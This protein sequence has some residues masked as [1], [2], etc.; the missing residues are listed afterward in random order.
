[1]LCTCK[2]VI[3]PSSRRAD[4]T[5]NVKIRIT[6]DRRSRWLPTPVYVTRD[7]LTRGYKLKDPTALMLAERHAAAVRDALAQM[8]P[9]WL[10]GRTVDDAVAW[11][12]SRLGTRAF[13][14]DLLEFG[15]GFAATKGE[16]T[17][18]AYR[19]ALNAL[20]RYCGREQ[21]DVSEVTAQLLREFADSLTPASAS[22]YLGK[23]HAV[24]QAAQRRYNDPDAGV[25]RI[26]RDPFRGLELE[27]PVRRGQRSLGVEA[28]QRIIDAQTEDPKLRRALDWFVISFALMGMNY[29]DLYGAK[30]PRR[31][32]LEYER[33]K[34]AGRRADGA[35][36]RVRVPA[37]L[38]PFVARQRA[39]NGPWWLKAR[40]DRGEQT[41]AGD[42]ND[43]LRSWAR[44]EGLPEFTFYA[45]RHTFATVARSAA[46]GIP[47]PVIEDCLNH[48]AQGLLDIY[49][50][51][52]W[53]V[54]DGA[55]ARVLA[56]F[57]W[58]ETD[59]K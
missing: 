29:I 26:P 44:A 39:K 11:V 22:S 40:R 15:R 23:L 33:R 7:Q 6:Y 12:R 54:L 17:G 19:V 34:T 36:M 24:W 55:N 49:A 10:D 20:G 9:F 42:I 53:D 58:P 45:A 31:G 2:A 1:M 43:R 27:R 56:L 47:Y 8:P 4:G 37:C 41:L 18:K 51:R 16:A 59:G 3:L 48:K 21:L 14:L 5:W 32:V 30:P 38:E 46:A 35:L 28:M 52:D 13:R 25:E 50:E 57:R